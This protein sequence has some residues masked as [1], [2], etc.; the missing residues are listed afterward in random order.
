MKILILDEEFPYPLNTG[1]RIRSFNLTK[2]IAAGHEVY[3]LAYGKPDS[4]ELK[5]FEKNNIK[6]I[7][8]PHQIPKKSGIL[9]YFRLLKNLFSE[10]PYIVTSHYSDIFQRTFEKAISQIGPDLIICEWS[11]YSIFIKNITQIKKMVVAHNIES[12][13]WQRYYENETQFLKKWYIKKQWEKVERFERTAFEWADGATAV[14]SIEA[15]EIQAMNPK[16]HV[17]V[18]DN[19]V[20]LEYFKPS[21]SKTESK[22]LIFVGSMNWR[23]NQDAIQYFVH[24]IFPLVKKKDPNISATFV[25]QN[26]PPHIEKLN[27]ISGIK[28]IGRVEDIRPYVHKAGVY[29]VPLRIG[30]G[31]RLKILEAF[32]MGKTVI[33]TPVGAEGLDIS[34]GKNILIAETPENFA[35]KI[36]L[37]IND[38]HLNTQLGLAGRKL[39]EEQYGW[40]IL[41]G[42]LDRFLLQLIGEK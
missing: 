35:E 23:P 14:S 17:Q 21:L 27:Q 18:V 20:D 22:E 25:G 26:P 7:V 11:P 19:G 39:V 15:S 37:P 6:P 33:S 1:K 42:K 2:R 13:I 28:I 5:E 9:F 31:T 24:D 10:Y 40:D 4:A 12:R 32:A 8:V 3:Y 38:K 29:I 41:A 16:M 34:D 36:L 30:G